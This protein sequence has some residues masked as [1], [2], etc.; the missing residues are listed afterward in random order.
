VAA[1]MPVTLPV[2]AFGA[3]A[4]FSTGLTMFSSDSF[5]QAEKNSTT[6]SDTR[7]K[8]LFI[9]RLGLKCLWQEVTE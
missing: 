1:V 7:D 2:G 6:D 8:N 9:K 5:W 3:E 4:G